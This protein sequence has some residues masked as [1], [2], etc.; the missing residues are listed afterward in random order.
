MTWHVEAAYAC[1]T[2][3]GQPLL[4][5]DGIATFSNEEAAMAHL[6]TNATHKIMFLS[7]RVEDEE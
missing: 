1:F 5:P 4:E 7:E 2:C 6:E 3:L